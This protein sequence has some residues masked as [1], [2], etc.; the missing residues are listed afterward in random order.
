M[1]F[2]SNA[3]FPKAEIDKVGTNEFMKPIGTG[4][5]MV[6]EW[7]V[8]DHLTLNKN[9]NWWQMG[10]DGKPQPYLGPTAVQAGGRVHDAGIAGAG[11]QPERLRGY[12]MEP[13]PDA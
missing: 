7:V 5:F 3:I 4:P 1:A 8:N 2:N 11:G 9:P 6:Q 12:P 13:D 10:V